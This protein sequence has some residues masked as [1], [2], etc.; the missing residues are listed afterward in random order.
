MGYAF[1]SES[2]SGILYQVLVSNSPEKSQQWI[3]DK[4]SAWK[5]QQS[6]QV[7]N[8]AFTAAPRFLGRNAV[9]VTAKHAAAL[10][11][12]QLEGYTVDRL[13]R[14]WWLIQLPATDQGTYTQA[15]EN[16]I[17]RAHV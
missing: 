5:E 4:H 1:N 12:F 8:L 10:A 3:S 6:L 2:V 17:G 9:N 14:I 7:F 11:P 15:I 13:F 16:Q